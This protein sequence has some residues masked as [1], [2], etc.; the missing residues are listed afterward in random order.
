MRFRDYMA[1]RRGWGC[2]PALR[3]GLRGG[4]IFL[5]GRRVGLQTQD[6]GELV[7]GLVVLFLGEVDATQIVVR[8]RVSRLEP[9]RALEFVDRF[10]VLTRDRERGTK[11]EVRL[12]HVAAQREGPLKML[13]RPIGL[14]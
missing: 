5:R 7:D 8:V 12:R 13:D 4:E 1:C 2:L 6:L 14:T 11:V 10:V 3:R 9:D